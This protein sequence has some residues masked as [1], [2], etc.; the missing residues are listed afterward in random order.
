VIIRT[1]LLNLLAHLPGIGKFDF[2][3]DRAI[4]VAEVP[5]SN[6]NNAITVT[7]RTRLKIFIC[8][9]HTIDLIR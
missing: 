4:N 7:K 2:V 8:C 9:D 6:I 3:I 5:G 1:D